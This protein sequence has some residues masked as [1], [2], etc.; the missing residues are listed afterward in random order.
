MHTFTYVLQHLRSDTPQR[1]SSVESTAKNARGGTEGHWQVSA[2]LTWPKR[3]VNAM[4]A[5]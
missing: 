5:A 3:V 1:G 4:A 2:T